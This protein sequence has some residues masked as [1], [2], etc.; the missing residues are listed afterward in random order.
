MAE[1]QPQARPRRGAKQAATGGE[2]EAQQIT[3]T[4]GELGTAS[5]PVTGASGMTVGQA[6][7]RAGVRTGDRET[8]IR[9]RRVHAQDVLQDHDI[10][11]VT[12]RV[13]G[14]AV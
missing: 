2:A 7:E 1:Q 8:L 5:V 14:G 13:R 6:L 3:I 10:V 4:V 12:G 9:G 11:V